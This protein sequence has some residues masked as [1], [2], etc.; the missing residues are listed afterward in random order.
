MSTA[1]IA[2][3][4]AVLGGSFREVLVAITGRKPRAAE[5]Q[6]TI[7]SAS[8]KALHS[9]LDALEAERARRERSEAEAREAREALERRVAD[10]HG[11]IRRQAR[12]IGQLDRRT[13]QLA[14]VIRQLGGTVPPEVVDVEP[15]AIRDADDTDPA[16]R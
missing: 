16:G 13:I 1:V 5:T 3:V 10:D 14:D 15:F 6:D 11:L 12:R 2:L 9:V 8:D 7:A 4:S